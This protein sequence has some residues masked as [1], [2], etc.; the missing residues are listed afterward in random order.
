MTEKDRQL[1]ATK[2]EICCSLIDLGSGFSRIPM[3]SLHCNLPFENFT[4]NIS[5]LEDGA[6][7]QLHIP[8][9]HIRKVLKFLDKLD[10]QYEEI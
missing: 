2:R 7:I 5:A 9:K 4:G 1:L 8:A 3:R 10:K 6:Y